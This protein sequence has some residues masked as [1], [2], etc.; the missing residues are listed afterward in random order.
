LDPAPTSNDPDADIRQLTE[1]T[2]RTSGLD[3]FNWSVNEPLKTLSPPPSSTEARS[4]HL[5]PPM[6]GDLKL[7]SPQETLLPPPPSIKELSGATFQL[8]DL[9]P[10]EPWGTSG[11]SGFNASPSESL[12]IPPPPPYPSL[13]PSSGAAASPPPEST[14]FPL[15]AAQM[16][17]LLAKQVEQSLEKMM[18]QLLP[19]LAERIL[20]QE[21]HRMLMEQQ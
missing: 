8:D 20:K 10:N 2:I 9:P 3:D 7:G 18:R 1:S 15:T 17:D 12:P 11:F 4:I 5:V 6:L 21:I 19:D 14:A 16:E 13:S